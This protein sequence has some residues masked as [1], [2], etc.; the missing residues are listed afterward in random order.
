MSRIAVCFFGAAVLYALCG[1]GLG[2]SMGASED[3]TL[4]ALH[5]HIN[6][7]GWAGLAI[8]GGFYGIAGDRA[9]ARIAWTNFVVSNVGNLLTLVLLVDVLKGKPPLMPWFLIGQL[10]VVLGMVIFGLAV[11]VVGRKGEAPA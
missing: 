10:L 8:M 3:Y 5:A 7:L 11:V 4:R 9:P 1:M 2:I 6:L